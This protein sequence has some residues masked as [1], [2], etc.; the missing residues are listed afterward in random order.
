MKENQSDTSVALTLNHDIRVQ[1]AYNLTDFMLN[2]MVTNNLPKSI[3]V[4]ECMDDPKENWY[5]DAGGPLIEIATATSSATA[6]STKAAN[7]HAS[8]G[9]ANTNSALDMSNPGMLFFT[10]WTATFVTIGALLA[11]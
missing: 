7:A 6:S 2:Y 1:T 5:R 4:G 11:V 8:S 3:T 10:A 9:A